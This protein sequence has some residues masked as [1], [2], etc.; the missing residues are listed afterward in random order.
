M[1]KLLDHAIYRSK[2]PLDMIN[3]IDCLSFLVLKSPLKG[4]SSNIFAISY[5]IERER[6]I[7]D[8]F[9]YQYRPIIHVDMALCRFRKRKKEKII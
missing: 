4:N 2:S 8:V 6:S 9:I 5:S 3:S 7:L 1:V